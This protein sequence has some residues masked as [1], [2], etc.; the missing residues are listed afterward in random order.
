MVGVDSLG[1]LLIY[2]FKYV[3]MTR[4]ID[5]KHIANKKQNK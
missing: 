4:P 5:I 1:T 3:I 2:I